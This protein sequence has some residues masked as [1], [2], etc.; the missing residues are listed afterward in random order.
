M[1]R[2]CTSIDQQHN[3]NNNNNIRRERACTLPAQLHNASFCTT[4]NTETLLVQRSL[5]TFLMIPSLDEMRKALRQ[6]SNTVSA[7]STTHTNAGGGN[8]GQNTTLQPM[9][10]TKETSCS[11]KGNNGTATLQPLHSTK[12]M[13]RSLKG[14]SGQTTSLKH[15]HSSKENQHHTTPIGVGVALRSVGRYNEGEQQQQ[16]TRT[17]TTNEIQTYNNHQFRRTTTTTI[18]AVPTPTMLNH[19][20]NNNHNSSISTTALLSPK[21]SEME[22]QPFSS[23][24]FSPNEY[25]QSQPQILNSGTRH[26]R[27]V[28]ISLGVDQLRYTIIEPDDVGFNKKWRIRSY[29]SILRHLNEILG[30]RWHTIKTKWNKIRKIVFLTIHRLG[31]CLPSL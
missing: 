25:A 11:L 6:M 21:Q 2:N 18:V 1:A 26:R 3:N 4:S 5:N 23:F 9:H 29:A 15:L 16:Q 22:E 8:S 19:N 7:P 31:I 13:Q 14:T 20:T 24:C 28:V 17:K 30:Q 12:E 10:S 27:G